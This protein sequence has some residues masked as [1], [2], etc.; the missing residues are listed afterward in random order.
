MGHAIRAA[1]GAGLR[2]IKADGRKSQRGDDEIRSRLGR[3]AL[4]YRHSAVHGTGAVTWPGSGCAQRC[5]GVRGGVVRDVGR[6]S[7]ELSASILREAPPAISPMLPPVL[8]SVIDKC[9]DKDPTQRY[10]SG[11]EVRAALEA[12]ATASRSQQIPV[13]AL[14][15]HEGEQRAARARRRLWYG[16]GVFAIVVLV[17]GSL[18][19]MAS[20]P[21]RGAS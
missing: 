6:P 16:A 18:L 8:Q 21:R 5:V 3:A 1:E 7:Y 13:A 14:A 4:D 9:L 11:G 12:A 17:I 15:V 20:S 10:R 2:T 19:W